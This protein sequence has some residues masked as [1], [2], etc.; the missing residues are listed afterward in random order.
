[1]ENIVIKHKDKIIELIFKYV[2]VAQDGDL[3]FKDDKLFTEIEKLYTQPCT[4]CH[5]WYQI[6]CVNKKPCKWDSLREQDL[7]E[8]KRF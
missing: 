7:F 8:K 5:W 2:Y 3:F 4:D 6:E 1:M